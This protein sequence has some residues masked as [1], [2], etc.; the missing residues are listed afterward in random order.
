M[1]KEAINTTEKLNALVVRCQSGNEEAF[2]ELV[3]EFSGGCYGYFYRLT[4]NAEVSNDLLS[5]LF[6]K[7]VEKIGSFK[8]GSFKS[9]LYRVASNIFYDYLR[10]R[11]RQKRLL[12]GKVERL[13]V[14]YN[15]VGSELE[16]KDQL[17]AALSHLDKD[18]IELLMLRFY[19]GMSFKELSTH[20]NEP[21]GT[22][23]AKVRRALIKLRG[24]M[25]NEE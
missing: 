25:S 11:Q 24:I 20:R 5:E 1:S 22:T 8:G 3:N 23:L 10:H 7:L 19:S 13:E 12:D 21:I 6:M 17:Q 14:P 4:G 9:W 15:T 16:N 18:T 2:T